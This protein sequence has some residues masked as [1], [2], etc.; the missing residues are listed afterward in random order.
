MTLLM[1]MVCR[2]E[3]GGVFQRS[4]APTKNVFCLMMRQLN[5]WDLKQSKRDN[6]REFY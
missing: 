2:S 5:S 4:I 1:H 3:Q 6:S